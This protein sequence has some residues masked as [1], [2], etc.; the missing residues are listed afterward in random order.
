MYE[1]VREFN[2]ETYRVRDEG[3]NVQELQGQRGEYTGFIPPLGLLALLDTHLALSR[4]QKDH[5]C[6]DCEQPWYSADAPRLD[7]MTAETYFRQELFLGERAKLL[8]DICVRAIL[9]AEPRDVSALFWLNY[10]NSSQGL[11]YLGKAS[12]MYCD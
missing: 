8:G 6:I 3:L 4:M 1:L 10:L 11:E 5:E 9:S 12:G 7:G 2:L